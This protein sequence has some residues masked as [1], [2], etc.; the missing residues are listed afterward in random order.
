MPAIHCYLNKEGD[1]KSLGFGMVWV[2]PI[3]TQTSCWLPSAIPTILLGKHLVLVRVLTFI[4]LRI[5][6]VCNGVIG[7]S[8]SPMGP[9]WFHDAGSSGHLLAADLSTTEGLYYHNRATDSVP[10]YV[11]SPTDAQCDTWSWVDG[12]VPK[13]DL[14]QGCWGSRGPFVL[15]FFSNINREYLWA[16]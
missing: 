5:F 8:P 11:A 1:D 3:F 6:N 13:M 10:L 16:H 4:F 9:R 12:C 2:F 7:V 14:V 15:F